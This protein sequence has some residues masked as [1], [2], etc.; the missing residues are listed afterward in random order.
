VAL[1]LPTD[2]GTSLD[3]NDPGELEKVASKGGKP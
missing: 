3:I 2:W 1:E